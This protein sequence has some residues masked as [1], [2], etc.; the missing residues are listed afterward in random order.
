MCTFMAASIVELFYAS[1]ANGGVK[2]TVLLNK[3]A[4]ADQKRG[5]L[6]ANLNAFLQCLDAV[7]LLEHLSLQESRY[8]FFARLGTF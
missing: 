3:L 1:F 7:F 4:A 6:P 2:F 8:T 5:G